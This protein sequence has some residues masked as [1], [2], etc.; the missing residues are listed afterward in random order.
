[1]R[2]SL[3]VGKSTC[4]RWGYILLLLPFIFPMGVQQLYTVLG[5]INNALKLLVTFI[6]IAF[7]LINIFKKNINMSRPT[8]AAIIFSMLLVVITLYY[9]ND[10]V[11]SVSYSAS[12][13]AVFMWSD[14]FFHRHGIKALISLTK[15]TIA[16]AVINAIM[17]I[18]SPEFFGTVGTYRRYCFISNDNSLLPFLLSGMILSFILV[19]LKRDVKKTKLIVMLSIIFGSSIY[20]T[21]TGTGVILFSFIFLM[22]FL[23][24]TKIWKLLNA[25]TIIVVSV[26]SVVLF[27]RFQ[28]QN[29]FGQL[30]S[31]VQK[32]V[33]FS[34][35]INL[36]LM[37][38]E[39]LKDRWMLGFGMPESD[40]L[41]T[42][43]NV[44]DFTS[45]NMY[46]QI[47]LW[48]GVVLL[49]SYLIIIVVSY[50]ELYCNRKQIPTNILLYSNLGLFGMLY[51]YVFEVHNNAPL[52]W[53]LL[54]VV[55]HIPQLLKEEISYNIWRKG[56]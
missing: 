9:E 3:K 36:W 21:W 18:V 22:I 52:F 11:R 26:A 32:D 24:K 12:F 13:V 2:L 44:R 35:R 43:N 7:Y 54:V 33:T 29:F 37:A 6:I 40:L 20:I 42:T 56:N 25:K 17:L 49:V 41:F 53:I 23:K 48:G 38:L 28:L 45:H 4:R 14:L 15:I 10:V 1:M 30:F 16:F 5:T 46:L 51:Y 8:S 50:H 31:A 19:E 55:Y 47:M 39:K 34:G 27:A